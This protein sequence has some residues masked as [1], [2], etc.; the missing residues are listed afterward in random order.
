MWCEYYNVFFLKLI[1]SY[2][3]KLDYELVY[4]LMVN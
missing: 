4:E 3:L 2:S 1:F